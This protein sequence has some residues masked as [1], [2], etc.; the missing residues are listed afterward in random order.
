[1]NWGTRRISRFAIAFAVALS[2][3]PIAVEPALSQSAKIA[4]VVNGKAVTSYDIQRRMAFLKLQRRKGNLAQVAADEMVDQELRNQEVAR[5]RIN[6]SDQQVNA[7]Y[8]RFASGNKMTV[9]QLNTVLQQSGVS[10]AHFKQ[11]IRAQMGWGQALSA[12]ARGGTSKRMSEQ[13]LVRKMLE[14]GGNKPVS[15]E[16]MLQ[17]VIFVV[18]AKD[19]SA[20]SAK[21]KRE[22]ENMRERFNGCEQTRQFT[23]GLVDVTV[24]DLGRHLEP[25][26][27]SDWAEAIK[28]TRTG[29]ATPV[30]QTERGFEFIGVCR[31]KEVS[32]D[33]VAEMLFQQESVKAADTGGLGEKYTAELRERAKIIKR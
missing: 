3:A 7:S 10:A 18:P 13:D 6:I 19:R 5:L 26:L 12:R 2:I 17:Q 31:A 14:K 4:Y 15:T 20:I 29:F 22:A 16:Y 24:R 30:R 27:P 25:A 1:M 8:E 11:Y 33:R 9:K 32:D 21:R 28:G 23:K